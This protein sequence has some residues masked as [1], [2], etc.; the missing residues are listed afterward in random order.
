LIGAAVWSALAEWFD[1]PMEHT[2]D[3]DKARGEFKGA[4]AGLRFPLDRRL[5]VALARRQTDE[6]PGQNGS[7]PAARGPGAARG[8]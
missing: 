1:K 3:V 4:V 8:R 2:D 5:I 6:A 7:A